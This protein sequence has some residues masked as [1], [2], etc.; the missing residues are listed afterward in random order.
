MVSFNHLLSIVVAI[1]GAAPGVLAGTLI[2]AVNKADAVTY[3]VS[4]AASKRS[5]VYKRHPT[6]PY[7]G[8]QCAPW[9]PLQTVP[10]SPTCSTNNCYRAFL[11]ARK[12]SDGFHCPSVAY[13]YCCQWYS[14]TPSDR[15]L[16]VEYGNLYHYLPWTGNCG[17]AGPFNTAAD[18]QNVVKKVDDVCACTIN[19]KVLVQGPNDY[20]SLTPLP[21]DDPV[22]LQNL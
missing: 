7:T 12:G 4:A 5:V 3:D 6:D 19:H 17:A 18:V 14:L 11:N 22:C 15:A 1:A 16:V 20:L 8:W 10:S 13:D 21:L 2:E 9:W